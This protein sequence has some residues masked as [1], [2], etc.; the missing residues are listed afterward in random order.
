MIVEVVTEL[1]EPLKTILQPT[2]NTDKMETD[3]NK[4]ALS[5]CKKRLKEAEDLL[6]TATSTIDAQS[7]K[8]KEFETLTNKLQNNLQKTEQDLADYRSANFTQK[9]LHAQN[10]THLDAQIKELTQREFYLNWCIH[11]E[12][13]PSGDAFDDFIEETNG[14]P[15]DVLHLLRIHRPD[16]INLFQNASIMQTDPDSML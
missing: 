10:L 8:I 4:E 11:Q 9:K 5:D 6:R 14:M 1:I 16:G 12:R 2:K 7:Q 13:L 15:D 3:N